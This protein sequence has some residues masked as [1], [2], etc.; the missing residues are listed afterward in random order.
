M[1]DRVGG[2]RTKPPKTLEVQFADFAITAI[3]FD[4]V[5]VESLHSARDK[6]TET[7]TI[8]E[9]ISKRKNSQPVDAME[10]AKELGISKDSAYERMRRAETAGTIKRVNKPEKGNRKL[11][12]PTPRPRFIPDPEELFQKIPEL[13]NESKFVHPLTGKWVIYRRGHNTAK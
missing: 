3:V 6:A 4:K 11:F 7:R 10:L 2:V 9:R 13:G 5:F 12:L 1:G 8:V